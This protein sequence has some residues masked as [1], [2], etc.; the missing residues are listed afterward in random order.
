MM[1]RMRRMIRM[2]KTGGGYIIKRRP[3]RKTTMTE[4]EEEEEDT[5]TDFKYRFINGSYDEQSQ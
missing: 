2:T 5:N 4:K 1:M 3:R